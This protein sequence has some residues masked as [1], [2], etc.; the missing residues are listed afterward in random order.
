M[1]KRIYSKTQLEAVVAALGTV[2]SADSPDDTVVVVILHDEDIAD[3]VQHALTTDQLVAQK[4]EQ[5]QNLLRI[6]TA[7]TRNLNERRLGAYHLKQADLDEVSGWAFKIDKA[8]GG[9]YNLVVEPPANAIL[10][11]RLV[12]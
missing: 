2:P 3:S 10:R 12:T 9:G 7:L 11:P 4:E 5:R 1:F 6:L 8:Q